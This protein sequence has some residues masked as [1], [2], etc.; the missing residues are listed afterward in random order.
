VLV[1]SLGYPSVLS[2]ILDL[3]EIVPFREGKDFFSKCWTL[4]KLIIPAEMRNLLSTVQNTKYL[5]LFSPT[6]LANFII[7]KI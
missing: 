5:Q 7:F 6:F 1:P 4:R 3:G 2:I